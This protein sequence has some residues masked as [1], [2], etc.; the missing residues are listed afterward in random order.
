MGYTSQ[1]LVL[2]NEIHCSFLFLTLEVEFGHQVGNDIFIAMQ[3]MVTITEDMV[4]PHF[5]PTSKP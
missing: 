3:N 5:P 4:C 2:K 1:T